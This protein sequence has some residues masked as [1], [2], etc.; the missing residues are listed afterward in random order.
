MFIQKTT[1]Q[2]GRGVYATEFIPKDTIIL[3]E[4]P[5]IYLDGN[6][7]SDIFETLYEIV[8]NKDKYQIFMSL[9]PN[10]ITEN[11]KLKDLNFINTVFSKNINILSIIL[12]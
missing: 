1:K 12:S 2:R 4:Y 11:E 10:S 3:R 8:S 9:Y 5:L 6:I 7:E